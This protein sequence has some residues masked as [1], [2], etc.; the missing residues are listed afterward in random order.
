[1]R[2]DIRFVRGLGWLAGWLGQVWVLNFS[3][4]WVELR[5][6]N[7]STDNS[8]RHSCRKQEQ[9]SV[10][11]CLKSLSKWLR[12]C[13]SLM[14]A[15]HSAFRP[16]VVCVC[17]CKCFMRCSFMLS[18]AVKLHL[19]LQQ[20]TDVCLFV[21]LS[22]VSLFVVSVRGVHPMCGRSAIL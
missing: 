13:Y 10:G 14:T 9:F 8:E 7:R 17:V 22:V 16:E 2:T 11:E 6:E 20:T 4:G 3:F 21:C 1:M 12:Y 5:W 15:C 19:R 18:V